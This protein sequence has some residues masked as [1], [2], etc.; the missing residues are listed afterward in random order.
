L[1]CKVGKALK[2]T[3]LRKVGKSFVNKLCSA[4]LERTF[5]TNFAP[6]SWKG[7]LKKLCS[8]KLER[9]FCNGFVR[10]GAGWVLEKGWN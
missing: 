5:E 8:A 4:K 7:L 6:Q 3:L 9:F 1:P 10:F 2:K